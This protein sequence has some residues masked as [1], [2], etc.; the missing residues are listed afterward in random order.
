MRCE[1]VETRLCARF[2]KKVFWAS[3]EIRLCQG[4]KQTSFHGNLHTSDKH[5]QCNPG[6]PFTNYRGILLWAC[7]GHLKGLALYYCDTAAST[8]K[9]RSIHHIQYGLWISCCNWFHTDMHS[10][11]AV[12]STI[13]LL[14]GLSA[15][16]MTLIYNK[17]AINT[18]IV[19]AF[20]KSAIKRLNC[21]NVCQSWCC[22]SNQKSLLSLLVLW[23]QCS[24][25]VTKSWATPYKSA[26]VWSDSVT[27]IWAKAVPL[28]W[29]NK[30]SLCGER[31]SLW[32]QSHQNITRMTLCRP[33]SA[34][35]NQHLPWYPKGPTWKRN[36][37][38]LPSEREHAANPGVNMFG[39]HRALRGDEIYIK[40][41]CSCAAYLRPR[42]VK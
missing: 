13:R 27:Q 12:M 29:K 3:R 33:S 38:F 8:D 34:L 20:S 1:Q 36:T 4:Q 23:L 30:V 2:F 25:T 9:C 37:V 17:A 28:A 42:S 22:C 35:V 18:S 21:W 24:A 31:M 19:R 39:I 6:F 26:Q 16:E 11:K 15:L 40:L 10:S 32:M 5:A 41:F 7:V 14:S